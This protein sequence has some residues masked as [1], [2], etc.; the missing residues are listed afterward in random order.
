MR[1]HD[2]HTHLDQ[3]RRG[4]GRS[5]QIVRGGRD[6]HAK[7][8]RGD[9]CKEQRGDQHT[10]CQCQKTFAEL[11]T[12]ACHRH[13]TDNNTGGG[14]ARAGNTQYALCSSGEWAALPIPEPDSA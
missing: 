14:A 11:E 5:N 2:R 6:T 12:Q 8:Y 10:M 4:D 1:R 9:H 3:D 7:N 13:D